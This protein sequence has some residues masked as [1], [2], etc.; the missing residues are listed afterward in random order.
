MSGRH[1]ACG[2]P[3][4]MVGKHPSARYASS[5]CRSR[6]WKERTGYTHD[7]SEN[8]RNGGTARSNRSGRQVS[9]QKGAREVAATLRSYGVTDAQRVAEGVLR[10]ALPEKQREAA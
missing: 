2:C 3:A 4:S 8:A 6:H 1:C 7:S 5:A 10:R 9:F